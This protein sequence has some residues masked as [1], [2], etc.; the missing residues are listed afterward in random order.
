MFNL[1]RS[2]ECPTDFA[3]VM[4]GPVVGRIYRKDIG[5]NAGKWCWSLLSPGLAEGTADQLEKA[6]AELRA[7]WFKELHKLSV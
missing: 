7:R 2:K 3:V 1:R 6:K 4:E 5:P